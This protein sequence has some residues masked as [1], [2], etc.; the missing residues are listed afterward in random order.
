MKIL[1]FDTETTG[2]PLRRDASILQ[3]A[4]WPHVVQLSFILYDVKTQ[5]SITCQDHIIKLPNEIDLPEE[6][7]KIHGITRSIMNR[8]GVHLSEAM[9]AFDEA[10][11]E[12]DVAVAHNISFDKRVLMVEA[13][14]LNRPQYFTNGG[15]GIIEHCT[16]DKNRLFCNIQM[17]RLNGGFYVK[18]PK[19]SELHEKI[20]GF[21]PKGMHDSMA[22]VLICLRCYM[23]KEHDI[24]ILSK[25]NS[26][27]AELYRL[28][29]V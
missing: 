3:T 23:K 5:K 15:K 2:L 17:K 14:R 24:D 26:S 29:C 10:I 16:M 1:V 19:L 21:M 7:I 27:I 13:H 25:G 12:A 4:L 18:R 6:S 20:F 8:K 9:D 28:Y 22:D 11:K